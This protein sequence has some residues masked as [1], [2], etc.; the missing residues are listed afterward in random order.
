V[1]G[2]LERNHYA[3]AKIM[4]DCPKGGV[5]PLP[6]RRCLGIGDESLKIYIQR[7]RHFV[8]DHLHHVVSDGDFDQP[9][10]RQLG[11]LVA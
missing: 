11:C 4:Q 9:T 6:R 10:L 2:L 5:V 7:G 3:G 8:A 1:T